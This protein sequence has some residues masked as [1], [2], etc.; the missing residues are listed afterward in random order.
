MS[1]DSEPRHHQRC[2]ICGGAS[3]KALPKFDRYGLVQCA[4]CGFVFCRPIPSKEDLDRHYHGYGSGQH[5]YVS[6]ITVKRYEEILDRMAPYRQS[7]KMLDVGCGSGH[8]L[9]TAARLGWEVY[10]TEYSD[11]LYEV[12]AAKGIRMALGP[13]EPE[14][15][16]PE[17]F[18][19][20]TSFEVLEHIN[21]P[22]EELAKFYRLLRPGGLVYCTTPNFNAL[23]RYQLGP[24]Y[25]IIS[26]PEHLSYYTRKTLREVFERAGFETLEVATT[27]LSLS[28]AKPKS[29][30]GPQKITGQDAPDEVA[31]QKIESNALLGLA[32]SAANG[33]LSATGTGLTLKGYF[34][35]PE[36]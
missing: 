34:R 19:V 29:K 27:G 3:L 30:S 20:L 7:G 4:A 15:Y 1:S 6:P 32:K 10:G 22:L 11:T 24:E 18:D 8:F 14:D 25:S 36:A 26:Y 28:R 31:R 33:L 9:V 12:C 23:Q 17:S 35:K 2:L 13:L 21:N 16:E 5:G